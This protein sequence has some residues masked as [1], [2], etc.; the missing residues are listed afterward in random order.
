[1]LKK[2]IYILI[3]TFFSI[4][5]LYSK[6][7]TINKSQIDK[8]IKHLN[9]SDLKIFIKTNLNKNYIDYSKINSKVKYDYG[10]NQIDGSFSLAFYDKKNRLRKFQRQFYEQDISREV[11]YYDKDGNLLMM[12]FYKSNHS[13]FSGFGKIYFSQKKPTKIFIYSDSCQSS[14]DNEGLVKCKKL[15]PKEFLNIKSMSAASLEKDGLL[16][17]KKVKEMYKSRVPKAKDVTYT[18]SNNINIRS[19][20]GLNSSIVDKLHVL[21]YLKIEKVA[22]KEN[23]APWGEFHWYKI[24]YNKPYYT[25][26]KKYGYIFGAFLEPVY[27]AKNKK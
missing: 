8:K 14:K 19:K 23:I 18:K 2:T 16:F 11:A 5:L 22:Q 3:Y 26:K 7:Q 20:P 25:N 27:E 12:I 24:S 21:I 6:N 9:N 4:S 10:A 13:T 17:A 15:P 1:M